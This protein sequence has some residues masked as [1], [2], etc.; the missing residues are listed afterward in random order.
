MH[1]TTRAAERMLGTLLKR[2]G[3]LSSEGAVARIGLGSTHPL[4][5]YLSGDP[6]NLRSYL[7]LDDTIVWVGLA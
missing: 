3:V 2:I 5:R 7:A 1:K 6:E 4:A